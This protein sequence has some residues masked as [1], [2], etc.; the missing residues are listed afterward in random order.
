MS[1]EGR[2]ADSDRW[3]RALA[4]YERAAAEVGAFERATAGFPFEA[5]GRLAEREER[6]R[7]AMS[8]RL[9]RLLRTPAPDVAALA[10]KLDLYAGHEMF[11][12]EGGEA[13]FE[14]MRRDARTLAVLRDSGSTSLTASSG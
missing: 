12:L 1:G 10:V 4:G 3:A 6:L 7:D 2:A 14:A 13:C 11:T 5:M 9:R 8:P